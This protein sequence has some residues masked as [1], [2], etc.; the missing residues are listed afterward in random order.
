M[1]FQIDQHNIDITTREGETQD[2]DIQV[3]GLLQCAGVALIAKGEHGVAAYHAFG[4]NIPGNI[5][6]SFEQWLHDRCNN[7]QATQF[8]LLYYY[9]TDRDDY[10][11]VYLNNLND[12]AVSLDAIAV[13][14][15][16]T[17]ITY[18]LMRTA[19]ANNLVFNHSG[20]LIDDTKQESVETC[21]NATQ[22]EILEWRN[23]VTMNNIGSIM[24]DTYRGTSA[25]QLE[26]LAQAN[27][28]FKF[29]QHVAL[30]DKIYSQLKK[31]DNP[32]VMTT[33]KSKKIECVIF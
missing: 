10:A 11:D 13:M 6:Q 21:H 27:R 29:K 32:L 15:P 16:N 25:N 5:I 8:E 17:L 12:L 3:F 31:P 24:N 26:K 33:K 23:L 1:V 7:A 14:Y 2:T 22:A 19:N 4:G 30:F 20:V 18:K 9:N 28:A